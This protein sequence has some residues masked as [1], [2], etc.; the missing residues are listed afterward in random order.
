MKGLWAVSLPMILCRTLCV[1][2]HL[3][4]HSWPMSV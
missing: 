1:C 3:A 4:V 2:A